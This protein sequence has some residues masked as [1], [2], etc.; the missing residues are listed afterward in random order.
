MRRTLA[1]VLALSVACACGCS[2][3]DPCGS[4]RT[5]PK[6]RCML[7]WAGNPTDKGALKAGEKDVKA[8]MVP[9]AY[10]DKYI[11]LTASD[12]GY[13]S[14]DEVK[15]TIADYRKWTKGY[16][17]PE[18][19][20]QSNR[21]AALDREWCARQVAEHCMPRSVAFALAERLAAGGPP[22]AHD[23]MVA[24]CKAMI[25]ATDER[26][27]GYDPLDDIREGN[28]AYWNEHDGGSFG[29]LPAGWWWGKL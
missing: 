12:G 24:A 18:V 3:I 10:V 2:L 23:Q 22:E 19:D 17:W 16:Y 21:Y 4:L 14:V 13:L 8:N 9:L 20:K 28:G 11:L 1:C 6:A 5:P 26:L 27:D 29:G 25:A 7:C 15:A